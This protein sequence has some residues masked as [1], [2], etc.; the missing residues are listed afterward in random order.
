M[1]QFYHYNR[2]GTCRKARKFLDTHKISYKE[3]D[4]TINPPPKKVL[5]EAISTYGIKKLFNTSGKE[6]KEKK[7]KDKI[8]SMTETQALEILSK[9]GRMIKRPFVVSSN[10]ITVGFKMEDFKK[11]WQK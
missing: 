6:Y 3:I 2:C 8:S 1:I 9:N 5:K 7:I 11:A 4:I 10:Q